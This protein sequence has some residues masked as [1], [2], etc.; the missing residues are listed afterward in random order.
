MRITT[1]TPGHGD[2]TVNMKIN[3][4]LDTDTALFEFSDAEVFET[5]EI[6]ENI[7]IDLDSDGN[8]VSMTVEHAKQ[9]ANL[10][11]IAFK[12]VV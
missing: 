6:N 3:Y 4:F 5:Q 9:N 12:K 7:N 10:E 11:E 1:E 2:M 8:L